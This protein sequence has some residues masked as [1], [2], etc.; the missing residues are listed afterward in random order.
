MKYFTRRAMLTTSATA[1]MALFAGTGILKAEDLA[2]RAEIDAAADAALA[3][4][5][6]EN[7]H[8][9]ALADKASAFL[10]F[11]KITEVGIAGVGGKRGKGVLRQAGNSLAYYRTTSVNFGAEIGF[12]THGYVVMFMTQPAAQRFA[13]KSRFEFGATEELTVFKAGETLD[14]NT[15][16]LK[17]EVVAF[18]FNEKGAMLNLTLEGTN[19]NRMDI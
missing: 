11:P 13:S 14:A 15:E 19:I 1:A 7:K 16:N 8:A 10:I 9:K 12:E 4:L 5:L 3:K 18:V 17:T 2:Q 6:A